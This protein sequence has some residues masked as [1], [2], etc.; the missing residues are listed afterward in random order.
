MTARPDNGRPVL[1][2]VAE[3]AGV[4]VPTVSKVINGREDVADRT[5]K[6]VQAVLDEL[7]YVSPIKPRARTQGPVMVDLVMHGVGSQYSHELLTGLLGHAAVAGVEVVVTNTPEARLRRANHELWAQRMAESGRKGLILST[8][9]IDAEHLKPYGRL[10]IPV[11]IVDPWSAPKSGCVTVGATNWAGGKTAVEHLV[12]LGHRRIAYIG[13]PKESES[14]NSRMHGYLA[15]LRDHDIEV[16]AD[17][18]LFGEFG[19]EFGA[20]GTRRL[21]ELEEPPTAIF[22]VCDYTAAGVLQETRRLGIRVPEDLSVVGFDGLPLTEQTVPRLTSVAQP[23]QDMGRAALRSVLLLA[24]G[25]SLDSSNVELA[26]TLQLRE[27]TMPPA[28]Y[29]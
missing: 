4:S 26:T 6:R 22:G 8:P 18:I 15:A 2:T 11:V 9:N 25:E 28:G 16:R 3:R 12:E 1:A 23:L 27:S 13:G 24:R 7:A 21:M 14:S 29:R 10:G 20:E 19:T 17:Y 5:R